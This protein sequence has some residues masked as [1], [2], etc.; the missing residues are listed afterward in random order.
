MWN[1][2]APVPD[3]SPSPRAARIREATRCTPPRT[4]HGADV[5]QRSR[6]HLP[7]TLPDLSSQRRHRPVF[8]DVV[9]RHEAVRA[10]DQVHDEDAPDAAVETDQ[11]VWRVSG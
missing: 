7:A 8:D 9:R 2:Y 10:V 1:P 6:A 3:P 5:Q 11:R 4:L